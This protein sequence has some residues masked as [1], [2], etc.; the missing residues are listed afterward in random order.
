MPP[1]SACIECRR[2]K[3]KCRREDGEANCVRCTQ[4]GAPC[5]VVPRKLGRKLGSKNRVR[6]VGG[7]TSRRSGGPL[8]ASNG[9]SPVATRPISASGHGVC[10]PPSVNLADVPEDG[11]QT[12]CGSPPHS[13]SLNMLSV[14]ARVADDHLDQASPEAVAREPFDRARFLDDFYD[15]ARGLDVNPYRG[16]TLLEEGLGELQKQPDTYAPKPGDEIVYARIDQPRFD[17]GLDYDPV[18]A[19]IVSERQAN[20]LYDVYW[21]EAKFRSLDPVISTLAFLRSRSALLTTVVFLV[22]AQSLP[23][24]GHTTALVTRLDNHAEWLI[25]QVEK[26]CFQ[27]LEICQALLIFV[28]SLGGRKLN[29]VW[30]L[31]AR[32]VT[33]CVELRLDTWPPPT[34]ATTPS[35]HHDACEERLARSVT[36]MVILLVDWESG[37]AFFRSRRAL[38]PDLPHVEESRL[39]EWSTHPL[40]LPYDSMACACVFLLRLFVKFQLDVARL[41]ARGRVFDITAHMAFVDASLQRWKDLWYPKLVPSDVAMAESDMDGYRFILITTLYEYSILRQWPKDSVAAARDLCLAAAQVIIPRAVAILSGTHD[42]ISTSHMYS[43]RYFRVAYTGFFTLRIISTSPRSGEHDMFLLSLTATLARRLI[44][45]RQH[46][47]IT[48]I[49]QVLGRR[50]MNSSRRLAAARMACGTPEQANLFAMTTNAS[51]PVGAPAEPDQP[52]ALPF[53][54]GGGLFSLV[55]GYRDIFPLLDPS[56][57]DSFYFEASDM[58]PLVADVGGAFHPDN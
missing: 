15:A 39:L 22:S 35:P 12:P 24:S 9:S 46:E 7:E 44:D 6:V 45:L 17:L 28:T 49:T 41:Q 53:E 4:L 19:G 58:V 54:L 18:T 20:D 43:Y 40:A 47:N 57:I 33:L 14:L 52:P 32:A 27:S 37:S 25:T 26:H 34:W 13:A 1:F 38:L 2:N 30:H 5:T 36:R 31:A 16:I 23:V 48:G 51:G 8:T 10:V 3:I 56:V 50:M 29:R 42:L 11:M 21:A 55:G